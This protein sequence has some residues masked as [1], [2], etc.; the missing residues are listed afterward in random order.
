MPFFI[1]FVAGGLGS[2]VRY[3][4]SLGVGTLWDGQFPLGT[5]LINL[6][7][8][9]GIGFLAGTAERIPI[10]PSLRLLLQTGFL[11]GFT[12]FSAF[13]LETF[14][15]FRRGEGLTASGYLVGSNLLGIGLVFA[16][17]FLARALVAPSPKV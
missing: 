15:L 7:G 13:G 1:V 16:G 9:F 14:Q 6:L 3:A 5:F 4:M 17:Y 12:T 8:C 11:G 10:D 2:L